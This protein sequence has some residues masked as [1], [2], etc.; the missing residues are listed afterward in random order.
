MNLSELISS[1]TTIIEEDM[2]IGEWIELVNAVLYDLTP[3][4]KLPKEQIVNVTTYD[5]NTEINISTDLPNH[6]ETIAVYYN[7]TS[8]RKY[9]LRKISIIDTISTGWYVLD[10]KIMLQ[11][12]GPLS[13]NAHV[14][15]YQTLTMDKESNDYV[16]NLPAKYHGVLLKGIV[17]MV[18]QK[19]EEHERKADFFKD[20]YESRNTMLAERIADVEPWAMHVAR[21]IKAGA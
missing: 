21:Q 1:V 9:S 19:F 16:F 20:Y 8:R 10:N 6:H 12:L 18:A 4:A 14:N 2:K 15:Y 3:Y 17:A 13:G 7:P 11:A 5:G